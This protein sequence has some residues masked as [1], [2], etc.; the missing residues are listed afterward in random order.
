MVELAPLTG[1]LVAA[2]DTLEIVLL[3]ERLCDILE[4]IINL[5]AMYLT[6]LAKDNP[7]TP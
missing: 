1:L 5:G 2:H 4:T 6:Y 7:K 3:Q